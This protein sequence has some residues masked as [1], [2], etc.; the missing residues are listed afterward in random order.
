[1]IEEFF[2]NLWKDGV[3]V[4]EDSPDKAFYVYTGDGINTFART[5]A[6]EFRVKFGFNVV[7]TAEKVIFIVTNLRGVNTI[8]EQ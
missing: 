8:E 3:F 6:G 4:P 1:M 5:Q 7:G 2:Y